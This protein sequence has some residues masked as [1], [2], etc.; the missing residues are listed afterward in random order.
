MN[1]DH[2]NW[3]EKLETILFAYR[4]SKQKSTGY[5]P[6]FMMFHRQPRLPIDSELLP[7][8]EVEESDIDE[9]V[10]RMVKVRDDLKDKGSANI[11]KAQQD[12]KEYYDKRHSPE[13]CMHDFK[14]NTTIKLIMFIFM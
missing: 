8:S 2:T 11:S 10:E 1:E 5:S 12:Q 3:D 13:V 4:A 14:I 9:F 6:F 7:M